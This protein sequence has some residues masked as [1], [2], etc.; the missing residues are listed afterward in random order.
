MTLWWRSQKQKEK[1]A[2]FKNKPEQWFPVYL[3]FSDMAEQS[4]SS[5]FSFNT[6][7]EPQNI[8]WT[9]IYK[10]KWVPLIIYLLHTGEN[11]IHFI[12]FEHFYLSWTPK[13]YLDP[14]PFWDSLSKKYHLSNENLDLVP[15]IF[16]FFRMAKKP[17]TILF[18]WRMLSLFEPQ[19]SSQFFLIGQGFP[20]Y[21]SFYMWLKPKWI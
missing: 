16:H 1:R 15:L 21:F 14:S 12:N 9:H 6:F 20:L 3:T 8:I 4:I 5:I 7:S 2:S 18:I 17:K 19:K 11:K 13:Y 10:I